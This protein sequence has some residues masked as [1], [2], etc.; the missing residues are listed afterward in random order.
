MI[1]LVIKYFF[2]YTRSHRTVNLFFRGIFKK[3]MI[4]SNVLQKHIHSNKVCQSL[5]YINSFSH[6]RHQRFPLL[7]W[8][9][10]LIFAK[11]CFTNSISVW[12]FYL[13]QQKKVTSKKLV[14]FVFQVEQVIRFSFSFSGKLKITVYWLRKK[15]INEKLNFWAAGAKNHLK[16]WS[17]KVFD[18][19][20][21]SMK[22]C[23]SNVIF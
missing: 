6:K 14:H 16:Q 11:Y 22:W 10:L 20:S 7:T 23:I 15:W 17:V 5:S 21:L 8:F 9:Q 19:G 12:Y 13:V 4:K 18:I 2:S 3:F 1:S